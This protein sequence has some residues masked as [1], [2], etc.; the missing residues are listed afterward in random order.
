MLAAR[1]DALMFDLDGVLYRGSEPV[2][3]APETMHALR[4]A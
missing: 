4:A 3:G 1:Y 2:P